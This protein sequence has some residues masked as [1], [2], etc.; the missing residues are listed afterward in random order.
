MPRVVL[1]TPEHEP[2]TAINLTPWQHWFLSTHN[3]VQLAVYPPVDL[4]RQY[5]PDDPISA[6]AHIVTI[7]AEWARI[8]RGQ[9]FMVLMTRDEEAAMRLKSSF[10]PG[11]LQAVQGERDQAFARGFLS[12][13]DRWHE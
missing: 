7:Y 11:Q 10:L 2:I 4:M 8:E 6:E 12:A 5:F 3:V 9:R 1:Y 13:I